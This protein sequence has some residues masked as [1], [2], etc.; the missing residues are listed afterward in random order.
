MAEPEPAQRQVEPQLLN[1]DD[2]N[3]EPEPEDPADTSEC[4]KKRRKKKKKSKTAALGRRHHF[5]VVRLLL[6]QNYLPLL[7]RSKN[8]M[9]DRLFQPVRGNVFFQ[10][11]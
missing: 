1:G 5:A 2:V 4:V 10:L 6:E 7:A 9:R 11:S 8:I 3:E